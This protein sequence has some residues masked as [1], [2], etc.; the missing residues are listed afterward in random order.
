L[1]IVKISIP[2]HALLSVAAGLE[3]IHLGGL[4]E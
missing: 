3:F 4:L 2:V 1:R